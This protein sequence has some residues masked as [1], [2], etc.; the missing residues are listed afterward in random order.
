MKE[1]KRKFRNNRTKGKERNIKS[2]ENKR[3]FRNIK[4]KG[5]KET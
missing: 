3:K 2:K 5:K 4:T 1:N